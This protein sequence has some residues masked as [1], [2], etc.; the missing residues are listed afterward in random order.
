MYAGDCN[1]DG[2]VD[3]S[4]AMCLLSMLFLGGN[5][6]GLPCGNGSITDPANLALMSWHGGADLDISDV[7]ALLNWKFLGGPPHVVGSECRPIEGCPS[8]CEAGA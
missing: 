8:V 7:T 3:I 4:D 2:E 1:G 6:S 5:P